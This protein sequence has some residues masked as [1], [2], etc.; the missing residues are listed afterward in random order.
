MISSDILRLK[1]DKE[2]NR[3][4]SKDTHVGRITWEDFSV[5]RR[6]QDPHALALEA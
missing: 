3:D 1:D 5:E 2:R 4:P 6:V